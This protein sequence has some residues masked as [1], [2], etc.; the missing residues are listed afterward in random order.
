MKVNTKPIDHRVDTSA[1]LAGSYGVYAAKQDAEALLRR[2]VMANLL[3]EDNFYQDGVSIVESIKALIPKVEPAQVAQIAVEARTQQKLR[4]VP[5]L[6]AREMARLPEHKKWVGSLLPQIILRPDELTEL[7]AL[8]WKDKK[9]PLSK[10]IKT[11]LAKAFQNFDAYQIAKYNRDDSVKL[12]DVLFL[13]HAK[14]KDQDQ[15]ELWKNLVGGKLIPPDTWEVA[16]SAGKNKKE[17][18]ERLISER[19]LGALAFVRNLRN[20]E[21]VEVD[22][23][24]ILKGFETINPRWLLPLNYIAAAT[25]TPRWERELET[26]MLRGLAQAPKLKGTTILVVDVSGSMNSQVSSK[27]DFSRMNVAA[28][29][30]MLAA[31]M[32]ERVTIYATAGNDSTR[33]HAT[34]LIK[35]RRGFGLTEEIYKSAHRLGGGGIFTRQC[36]EYIK[37]EERTHPERIIVISD[38]QDCDYPDRRVP[39]PF[40][41]QNYVIDVAAHERGVNYKGAWTAE[42]SGWS[43]HFLAYIAALEGVAMNEVEDN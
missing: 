14:P 23:D 3:W 37:G 36:L 6:I 4:H 12:R 33:R 29:M 34:E 10:Q 39:A 13:V 38:S 25:A 40:G 28:A 7:I 2:A 32:C 16:L 26:L 42:V 1:R 30:A 19:K 18:W 41:K 15:A 24:V 17:T 35:P 20:M 9:Q 5:L 11:G 43:E 31:E 8:Y 21:Q 22:R 27:S